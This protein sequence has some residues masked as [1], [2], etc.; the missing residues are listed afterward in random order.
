MILYFVYPVLDKIVILCKLH[1]S[2]KEP[3]KIAADETFFFF[4]IYLLKTK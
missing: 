3:S 4:Y 2:L 1:L